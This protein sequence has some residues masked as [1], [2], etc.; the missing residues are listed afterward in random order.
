VPTCSKTLPVLPLPSTDFR[1]VCGVSGDE[2]A[3]CGWRCRDSARHS[4]G[5]RHNVGPQPEQSQGKS[6]LVPRLAHTALSF[7]HHA[8]TAD[9]LFILRW[10][11]VRP[12]PRLCKQR[13]S[14]DPRRMAACLLIAP[15]TMPLPQQQRSQKIRPPLQEVWV[16]PLLR[17]LRHQDRQMQV[18]RPTCS[19]SILCRFVWMSTMGASLWCQCA[20]PSRSSVA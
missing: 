3:A 1:G 7:S 4:I 20:V 11:C 2:R 14:S 15:S 19:S 12:K 16:S 5:W 18:C 10:P 13:S 8:N 6:P 17:L 9:P